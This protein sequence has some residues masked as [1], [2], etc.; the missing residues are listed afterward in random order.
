MQRP[1]PRR[2]PTPLTRA[3]VSAAPQGMAAHP[4]M[5]HRSFDF[6]RAFSYTLREALELRRDPVR[7]VMALFGS[8]MLML[9]MG[10]GISMDVNDLSFAVLDRDQ[11]SLSRELCLEPLRLALLC[12]APPITDYADLDRRMRSGELSLALEIPPGFARDVQRGTLARCRSAPGSTAPCRSAPR[13][14]RATCRAC[15]RA[16]WPISQNRTGRDIR[17]PAL[18]HRDTLSLQPR[19][20]EPAGHGAGRHP[21]AAADDSGHA[22][23]AGRGAREGAGLDHQPLRHAQ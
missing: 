9:V 2:Y 20:E 12:R 7:L 1:G 17:Q 21:A 4:R 11:T 23:R 15:T 8:L 18:Q 10:Y 13:P 19:R 22:D 3:P 6:A 14:C 5:R 16:G